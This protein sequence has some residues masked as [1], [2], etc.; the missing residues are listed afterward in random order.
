VSKG[1][2]LYYYYNLL[3]NDGKDL[4][5]YYLRYVR[6]LGYQHASS[7]LANTQARITTL[8]NRYTIMIRHCSPWKSM[9]WGRFIG[10]QVRFNSVRVKER[11]RE[12]EKEREIER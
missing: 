9:K 2:L 11:K 4:S 10:I 3:D 7:L 5:G 1:K 6:V 8:L 12:R